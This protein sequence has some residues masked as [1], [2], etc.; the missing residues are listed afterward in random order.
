MLSIPV[1]AIDGPSASGKGTVAQL[2]AEQLGFHYLDSGAIYR[3]TALAAKNK[4]V[5]W[6]DES[7]VASVAQYL[8]VV[9]EGA[10][11][12]LAGSDVTEAIRSEEI[13]SGA[14][15]I[16]ALPQVRLALLARQQAFSMQPGL[17]ADGRDMA[18]VVFPSAVLK[19]FLTASASARAERRYKQLIGRGE[20]ADLAVITADLEARDARDRE[21]I[22]A[23]LAQAQDALLLDT[24][25]LDIQ[26]AVRQVLTWWRQKI[27]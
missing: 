24:T 20:T 10:R 27:E 26:S 3:L 5:S 4:G 2:V 8:D 13:G 6:A 15:K 12:I 25:E 14:S 1:I 16:A 9:F 17:V 19:V 23:P 11:I 22:V 7:A 18:S 21:R